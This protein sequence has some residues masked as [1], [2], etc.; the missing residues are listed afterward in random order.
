MLVYEFNGPR[1]DF[2]KNMFAKCSA[3]RP[4]TTDEV[5]NVTESLMRPQGAFITGADLLID[6][7][8]VGTT[9]LGGYIA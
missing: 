7:R 5:A 6:G 4:G 2:Y 3:G 1:G 8:A 9:L